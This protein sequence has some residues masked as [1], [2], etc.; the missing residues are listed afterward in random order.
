MHDSWTC[1]QDQSGSKNGTSKL[2]VCRDVF[3]AQL[4]LVM[5][6]KGNRFVLPGDGGSHIHTHTHTHTQDEQHLWLMALVT[7]ARPVN[8]LCMHAG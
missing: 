5:L 6:V 8:T 7:L 4:G 2:T 1:W 3:A